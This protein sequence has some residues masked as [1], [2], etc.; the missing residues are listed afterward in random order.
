MGK[1]KLDINSQKLQ[2]SIERAIEWLTSSGIQNKV[3]KKS[4]S[5]NAW[6]DLYTLKSMVIL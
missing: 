5:V 3:G 2:I 4:G 1:K 6:Y